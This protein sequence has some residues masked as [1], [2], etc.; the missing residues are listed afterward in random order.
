V[1][2]V[3]QAA[4]PLAGAASVSVAGLTGR[5]WIRLPE[6][7]D[8]RWAAYWTGPSSSADGPVMRTI[9]EC[10]QSVLWN[11]TSALA[12]L[13]QP[14]PAG[15]VAVPVDDRPPSRLVVTWRGD[16]PSPLVR[17]FVRVAAAA[18]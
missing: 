4:D 2:L 3:V 18:Q 8:A 16:R 9:Q 13:G 12:P 11:G 10:L 5:R 14:L 17:S 7:T 15:L 6:G 1:G